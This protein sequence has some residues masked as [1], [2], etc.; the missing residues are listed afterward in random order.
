MEFVGA[1][2]TIVIAL[3]VGLLCL[4]AG[5]VI[6]WLGR[7]MQPTPIK[8]E[9]YE[10]GEPTIGP[11]AV[12]LR[13]LFYLFALIFVIFDVEVVFLFPWAV[14]FQDLGWFAF[15]EMTVFIGILLLGLAYAWRKGALQWR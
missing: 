4:V 10:C 12:R 11:T 15:I 6:S 9:A 7:P 13:P 5:A 1:Y 8:R 14:V 3:V 2:L